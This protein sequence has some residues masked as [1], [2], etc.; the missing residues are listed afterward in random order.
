MGRH[1]WTT[2][3]TV[4]N[5]P[6]Q[7]SA[8]EF[9]RNGVFRAAPGTSG[10]LSWMTVPDGAPLGKVKYEIRSDGHGGRAI[11]ILRQVLSFGGSLRMGNGQTIQLTTSRPHWG[12][13]RF[14]FRCE[15]G[16]RSGSLYL[17]I[18]ETVFRCRPC[19]ELTYQSAQEH[20]TRAE[21]ERGLIEYCRQLMA[22]AEVS[23]RKNRHLS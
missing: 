11:F 19:Y 17:P 3:L 21:R 14:W 22:S 8:V 5:C 16:R 4:E 9:N 12:G 20:N 15:C 7:L 23:A 6:I 13:E 1:S 10:T 2:R 18:G